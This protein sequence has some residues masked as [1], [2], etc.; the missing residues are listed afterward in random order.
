MKDWTG[1]AAT[2]R[3]TL[4]ASNLSERDRAEH[5]YYATPSRAGEDLI[6]VRPDI[7][8]IW[9]CAVGQGHLAVGL[10]DRVIR[11]SDL[12]QRPHFETGQLPEQLDF[13][14]SNEPWDG[15][16]VTNPPFKYAKE[17][18]MK[19]NDLA[20]QGVALFLR[21]QFLESIKRQELFKKYPPKYMY[22]YAKRCPQCALNGDF[23]KPTGNATTYCWFV[24]EK[25]STTEPVVRW[26]NP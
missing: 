7:R 23:S 24:W 20:S 10:G 18:A 15:W 9:E 22:V 25:D 8:N 4:G 3:T 13:L 11:S 26:I 16:I 2:M 21:I 14:E 17:F 12:I 6:Q 19:A 5:D 1:N